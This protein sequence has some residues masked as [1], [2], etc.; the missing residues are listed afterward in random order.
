MP[1]PSRR[2]APSAFDLDA[3]EQA[4]EL[5]RDPRLA[6]LCDEEALRERLLIVEALAR[7]LALRP[8]ARNLGIRR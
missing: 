6:F 1:E 7:P 8:G 3:D 2:S 4:D 5:V